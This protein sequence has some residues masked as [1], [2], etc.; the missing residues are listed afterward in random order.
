MLRFVQKT[1]KL[2]D[3]G[4]TNYNVA[5]EFTCRQNALSLVL[6]LV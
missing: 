2:L 1:R 6:L 4:H 3:H 5:K